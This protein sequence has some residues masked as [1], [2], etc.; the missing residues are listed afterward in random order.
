MK[1]QT[2]TV[3]VKNFSKLFKYFLD[4]EPKFG[5]FFNGLDDCTNIPLEEILDMWF[6]KNFS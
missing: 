1:K 3:E 6:E 2:Y 4:N 5:E